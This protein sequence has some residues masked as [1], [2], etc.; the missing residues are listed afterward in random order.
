MSIHFSV[1]MMGK[2]TFCSELAASLSSPKTPLDR[3]GVG[4]GGHEFVNNEHLQCA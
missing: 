3:S 1:P 2:L 4:C